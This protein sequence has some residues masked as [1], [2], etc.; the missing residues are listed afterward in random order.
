MKSIGKTFALAKRKIE[1]LEIIIWLNT[2]FCTIFAN[3]NVACPQ[4][5]C[6]FQECK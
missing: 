4:P 3:N 5:C 2:F 6:L 1:N